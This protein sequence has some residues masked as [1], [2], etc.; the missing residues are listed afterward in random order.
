MP[1]FPAFV[2]ATLV[3]TTCIST[4]GQE[5]SWTGSAGALFMGRSDPNSVPLLLSA[6]GATKFNAQQM[7]FN[8]ATGLEI[9]ASRET[10]YG[11]VEFRYFQIDGWNAVGNTPFLAADFEGY[12]PPAGIGAPGVAT[13]QNKSE[14]HSGE[15][16]IWRPVSEWLN[17]SAGFRWAELDD[18]LEQ[19]F[20]VPGVTLNFRTDALNHLYGFQVGADALLWMGEKCEISGIAKAGIYGNSADQSTTEA[21]LPVGFS[22]AGGIRDDGTAFLGELGVKGKWQIKPTINLVAEYRLMWIDGVALAPDQLPHTPSPFPAGTTVPRRLDRSTVFYS[23]AF[24]G[25][26]I[27]H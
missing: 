14:L 16:N 2:L 3:I 18:R 24:I 5:S 23:G 11:R 1:R 7:D 17:V 20:V 6:A 13:F 4:Y 12:V 21:V 26:E 8:V 19:A 9:G 15:I 25:L 10:Q 22:G 27:T